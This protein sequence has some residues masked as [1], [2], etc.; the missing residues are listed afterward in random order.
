[1]NSFQCIAIKFIIRDR[2]FMTVDTRKN[3][4]WTSYLVELTNVNASVILIRF[5]KNDR[6]FNRASGLSRW[7][8]S[9]VKG[10]YCR[11]R[12]IF[13]LPPPPPAPFSFHSNWE[14]V[15]IKERERKRSNVPPGTSH[16]RRSSMERCS[17]LHSL[18][19][20]SLFCSLSSLCYVPRCRFSSH[21]NNLRRTAL[22]IVLYGDSKRTIF[23]ISLTSK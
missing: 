4:P 11:A 3:Q 18:A 22:S 13:F 19:L 9:R 1:M 8:A 14:R 15:K 2:L 17:S 20:A 7:K 5:E 6:N 23:T 12:K 10:V 21:R 16:L